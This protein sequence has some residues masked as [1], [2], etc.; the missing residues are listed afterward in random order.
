MAPV[1]IGTSGWTY[2]NW[3]GTFYSE[4]LPSA[5]FLEF[6]AQRFPTTEVNYSFYHLPRPSAYEKCTTQVPE[7]FIFAVK[8]SRLMTHTKRLKG[9]EEPWRVFLQ[10]AQSL[11]SRLGPIL[12]QF[13]ASFRCDHARLASF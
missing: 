2:P 5:R 6:Y 7:G 3:R 1:F 9:V 11:G 4:D 13:P 10:N 12:F 8:A